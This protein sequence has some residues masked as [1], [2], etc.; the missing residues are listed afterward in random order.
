MGEDGVIKAR[1]FVL[2]D[3]HGKT[4]AELQSAPNGAVA[5]TFHD[6]AGKMCALF[7][8]DPR[9]APTLALIKDG[10]VKAGV[11]LGK[12]NGQ[13]Q[14]VLNGPGKSNVGVDFED[15]TGN[16]S[17][18]LHDQSGIARVSIAMSP[19]GKTEISLFDEQGYV[20][21]RLTGS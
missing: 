21:E 3:E 13:P 6:L 7:G 8:L 1:K 19:N 16:A 9:Q 4:R 14:L 17:V 2:E 18:V 12:N 5:L 10:K 20:A 11:E 15:R